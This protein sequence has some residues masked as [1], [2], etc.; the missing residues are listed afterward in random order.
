MRSSSG[1]L[2]VVRSYVITSR[3]PFVVEGGNI[4]RSNFARSQAWF[5]RKKIVLRGF[6]ATKYESSIIWSTWT[7]SPM[8]ARHPFVLV[9]AVMAKQHRPVECMNSVPVYRLPCTTGD[10]GR[11]TKAGS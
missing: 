5:Q 7:V 9:A 8:P 6:S 10:K 3:H 11:G 2:T 4:V 1:F